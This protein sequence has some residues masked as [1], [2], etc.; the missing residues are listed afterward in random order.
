M[1]EIIIIRGAGDLA[2]EIIQK[3]YRAGINITVTESG[4]PSFIRKNVSYGMIVNL[5]PIT[6]ALGPG[7][8]AG[9]DADFVIE[10]MRGHNLGRLIFQGKAQED[11]GIPGVIG[12][13]SNLRVVYSRFEGEIT[14][15]KDI[16]DKVKRDEVI[17]YVDNHPIKAT[18]NG[19]LRGMIHS[20]FKVTKGLKIA[21]KARA[22]GGATLEA[23]LYIKLTKN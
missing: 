17:A 1:K 4:K 9:I 19:L 8:S 20:R 5:A 12:G 3:F 15:V 21:D 13:E 10:T 6:I 23:Y 7:F 11:T 16:G 18:I 2:S 22:L 14:I